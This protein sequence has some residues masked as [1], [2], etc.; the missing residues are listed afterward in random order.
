MKQLAQAMRNRLAQL[1][2]WLLSGQGPSKEQL[3]QIG[4]EVGLQRAT[5]PY[6]QRALTERM[7]RAMGMEQLAE[8]LQE[9]FE[10]LAEAG[11]SQEALQQLAETM[12][13]NAE[14]LGEQVNQFV[15]ASIARQVAEQQPPPA[16]M[17]DL[18]QRPFQSLSQQ[19]A[20]DLRNEV[21]RLAAQLR[22]RAS[23]R[24]RRGKTGVLDPKATIRTNLRYRRRAH[25]DQAP[26]ASREAETGADLRHLDVHAAGGAVPAA[27]WSMSCRTR[28]HARAASPSS[29]T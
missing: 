29:T 24:H 7:L 21:R 6:Q 18:M 4:Q 15:G 28:W 14:A 23:L 13:A 17:S 12:Q 26:A 9:M 11:M 5:H 3:Q 20:N 8:L 27:D 19:E 10:Q 2:N 22:S 25:R 16:R 1:L